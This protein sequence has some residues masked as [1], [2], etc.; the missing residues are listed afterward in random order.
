M[1]GMIT[2]VFWSGMAFAQVFD[3]ASVKPS[4]RIVGKDFGNQ[5]SVKPRGFSARNT[6]LKRLIGEAY[7]LPPHQVTGGM[8][9]LDVSEYDRHRQRPSTNTPIPMYW[10]GW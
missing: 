8:N 1:R 5:I 9:W 10:P 2:V 6:T 7:R 3:V 4:E